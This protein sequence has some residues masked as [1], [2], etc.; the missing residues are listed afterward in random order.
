MLCIPIIARDTLSAL[1]KISEAR[2]YADLLEIR[3]DLMDSFDSSKM[4][5][6]AGKPVIT[7]YRS[8][9]EGGHG[10]ND[11]SV[12]AD[13]L[14]NAAKASSDFIDIELSMPA[15]YREKILMEKRKSRIIISTHIMDRTPSI[16]TLNS[17]MDDSI[18][19][20]GDIVKIITT[21]R[22]IE[23]NLRILNLVSEARKNDIDIIAF[24]MGPLGRM[25][26]IFSLLM[27]GFL[28]FASLEKGEESASGQIPVKEMR[29]LL[30]YFKGMTGSRKQERGNRE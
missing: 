3:L 28:T 13:Y 2:K 16:D 18:E 20:G 29:E 11:P 14:V 1:E 15:K 26:R 12:V 24:C 17:L 10:T 30:E 21:A 8:I 4:I 23:D 27:G 6:A 19:A 7:T 5:K 9:K 25:S 22:A